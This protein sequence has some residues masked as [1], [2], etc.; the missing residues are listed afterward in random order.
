MEM[1]SQVQLATVL[2]QQQLVLCFSV[3][4]LWLAVVAVGTMHRAGVERVD[5]LQEMSPTPQGLHTLCQLVPVE[6]VKPE[7]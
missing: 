5:Y 4:W 1:V 6:L 3:T 2:L 7:L